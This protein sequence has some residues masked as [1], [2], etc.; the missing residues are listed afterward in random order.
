[1][2]FFKFF[3]C[4]PSNGLEITDKMALIRKCQ[5]GADFLVGI[6]GEQQ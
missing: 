5:L 4:L 2:F 3:W 1:M 6:I